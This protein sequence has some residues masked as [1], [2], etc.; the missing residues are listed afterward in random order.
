V[1]LMTTAFLVCALALVLSMLAVERA[2][3]ARY[4]RELRELQAAHARRSARRV[5]RF[6]ARWGRP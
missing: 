2:V 4:D 6:E 3:R 1:T 5:A